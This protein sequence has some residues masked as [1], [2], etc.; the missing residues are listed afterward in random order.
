MGGNAVVF[1][2]LQ[3]GPTNRCDSACDLTIG[4][5][6]DKI[7]ARNGRVMDDTFVKSLAERVIFFLRAPERVRGVYGSISTLVCT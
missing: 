2:I 7:R 3:S 4:R 5:M 1:F 6:R